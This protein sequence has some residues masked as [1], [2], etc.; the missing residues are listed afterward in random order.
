MLTYPLKY[1]SEYG[2]MILLLLVIID[3]PH[4]DVI[5]MAKAVKLHSIYFKTALITHVIIKI[6]QKATQSV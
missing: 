5:P 1:G 2:S 6:P 4:T 3:S